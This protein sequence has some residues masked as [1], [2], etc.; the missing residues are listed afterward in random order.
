MKNKM[1]KYLVTSIFIS[2]LLSFFITL[3]LALVA[4][5]S[6]FAVGTIIMMVL[7][8]IVHLVIKVWNETGCVDLDDLSDELFSTDENEDY[9]F[10]EVIED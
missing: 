10:Q 1:D 3:F 4:W 6:W 7:I 9:K 2:A 8:P 5:C